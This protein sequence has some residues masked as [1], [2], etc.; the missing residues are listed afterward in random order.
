M[1]HINATAPNNAAVA[2]RDPWRAMRRGFMGRC[3]QCN[4]GHIFRAFLKVR[5]RCEVCGEALH[6]HRADD[7]PPY[8]TILV[9]AHVIGFA[10]V[11]TLSLWDLP[12]GVQIVLWPTAVVVMSLVL[13]PRI[14]GALIALQWALRMHGFD[15]ETTGGAPESGLFPAAA[16]AFEP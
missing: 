14:K 4:E 7:A 9:V 1:E 8:F 11:T 16:T 2:P 13:L 6:H 12:M 10:M 5:D 15:D 3:P